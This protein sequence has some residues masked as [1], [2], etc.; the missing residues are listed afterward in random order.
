MNLSPITTGLFAKDG[1]D[2]TSDGIPDTGALAIGA[3]FLVSDAN[4]VN[5][6]PLAHGL[7]NMQVY[8][9]QSV[10][11]ANNYSTA[12]DGIPDWW[13]VQNG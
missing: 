8:L 13:L 2:T 11:I 1:E 9:N 4:A 7:D 3:N 10:L 5:P 6:N 12:N